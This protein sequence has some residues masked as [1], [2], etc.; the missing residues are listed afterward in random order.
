MGISIPPILF[1]GYIFDRDCKKVKRQ[2]NL[3]AVMCMKEPDANSPGYYSMEIFVVQLANG[4]ATE[5]AR[6]AHSFDGWV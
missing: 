2:G 1:T 6:S 3:A 5:I 4:T